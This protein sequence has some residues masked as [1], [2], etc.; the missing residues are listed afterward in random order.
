MEPIGAYMRES[1][2]DLCLESNLLNGSVA[3][4]S[5]SAMRLIACAGAL[6]TG[7][8]LGGTGAGLATAEPGDTTSTGNEGVAAAGNVD[9]E[10]DDSGAGESKADSEPPSSTVGNG[11]DDT[12]GKTADDKDD[13]DEKQP[14]PRLGLPKFKH[15]LAVP[16]F[17]LPAPEEVMASGWPDPSTFFYTVDVPVPSIDGF[18][19]ALAQPEPEPE[20]VPGPA[21]RGQ[22]EE[23]QAPAPDV[24]DVIGGGG[25]GVDPLA[26]TGAAPVFRVPLVVAPAV[27][28]PGRIT[29]TMPLGS[30][31]AA[32]PPLATGGP[33]ASAGVNAP[34]LRGSL[35]PRAERS[36]NTLTPMSGQ[37]T[38]LG[39]PRS[40]QNPTIGQLAVVAL[41]G[42][43]GLMFLT[44]SGSVIGY[45]QANSTRYLRTAGAE[46]FLP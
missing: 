11:R 14:E 28:I 13:Q 40:L 24:V 18:L 27:P 31:A 4:V 29:S 32:G 10:P 17:R 34:L 33:S 21:F 9:A 12:E 15:S 46:R 45:R 39:Y 5:A 22:I 3:I 23:P 43:G 1:H 7:L 42:V 26:N 38:R 16:V 19:S 41:P 36:P 2:A 6:T 37:T 25:G 20:P 44:F 35:S 8:L 30:S